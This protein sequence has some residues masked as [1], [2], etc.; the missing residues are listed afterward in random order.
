MIADGKAYQRCITS[1]DEANF[2]GYLA[3]IH[4]DDAYA[5]YSGYLFAQRQ[6]LGELFKVDAERAKE[7]LKLRYP[8]VQRDVDNLRAY[9][10]RFDQGVAGEVG[11][12]SHAVN[13]AYLKTNGVKGGVQSYQLSA[14]LLIVYAKRRGTLIWTK[15]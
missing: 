10:Q 8:G 5:R 14:K 2:C 13:D 12:A 6:L 7:L 15:E 3:C 11:K 4:S 1:E 9:W